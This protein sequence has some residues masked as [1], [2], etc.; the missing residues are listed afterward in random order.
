MKVSVTYTLNELQRITPNLRK[1]HFKS[2]NP[3]VKEALKKLFWNLGCTLPDKIEIDE[4]LVTLNKFGCLDDSPRITVFERQDIVWL[5]TRFASHRVR[6]L[7]DDVSMMREMDG[8][9]NQRSFDVCN[10]IELV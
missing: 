1:E 9:T 4:G 5:K 6:C 3:K 2:D 8:I 10:G 7:T